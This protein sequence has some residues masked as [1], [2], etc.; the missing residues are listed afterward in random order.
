MTLKK[1]ST[2][3]KRETNRAAN[4]VARERKEYL[5]MLQIMESSKAKYESAEQEYQQKKT[6]CEKISNAIE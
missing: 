3:V 5:K 6:L 1:H 2:C 4:L